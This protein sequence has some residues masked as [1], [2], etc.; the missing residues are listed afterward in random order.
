ME[1]DGFTPVPLVMSFNPARISFAFYIPGI[2][3]ISIKVSVMMRM[4]LFCK[5][6]KGHPTKIDSY[7]S[8]LCYCY[9]CNP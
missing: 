2:I 7:N 3:K 4:P 1:N 6:L 8:F 5:S 9:I